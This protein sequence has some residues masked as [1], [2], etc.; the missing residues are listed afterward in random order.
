M[1]DFEAFQGALEQEQEHDGEAYMSTL[2]SSMCLVLEEF[3]STLRVV[4]VS[5]ATGEGMEELFEQ[6]ESAK[7]EWAEEYLPNAIKMAQ[8]KHGENVKKDMEKLEKDVSVNQNEKVDQKEGSDP[9]QKEGSDPDQKEGSDPD[10]KEGSDP[11]QE[12]VSD[13]D[14]EDVSDPDQEEVSDADQ[15]DVS[16]PDQEEVSDAD[17][18]DVS[19]ADQ[20]NPSDTIPSSKTMDESFSRFLDRMSINN[21]EKR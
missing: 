7:K 9:D 18:E 16:D 8:K 17:Q 2:V 11:D 6:V 13:P 19:D 20:E 1:Q 21:N 10:Q 15:E 3:Y 12:D 5:A 4:G 14:Q